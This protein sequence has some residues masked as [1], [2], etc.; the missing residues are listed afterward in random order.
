MIS[1]EVLINNESGLESKK[2][3]LFIQRASNYKSSIWIEMGE[4]KANAKSLLGMLSLKI[5][6]GTKVNLIIEGEDEEDAIKGLEE[7]LAD[8]MEERV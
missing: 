4:R 3:A 7:F 8:G 1:K 6:N 5:P 2:A